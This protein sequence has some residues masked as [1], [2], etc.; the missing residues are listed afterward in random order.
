MSQW[1]PF[2]KFKFGEDGKNSWSLEHI[3][4]VNSKTK[5]TQEDWQKWLEYHI[6]QN[7]GVDAKN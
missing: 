4:A 3:N 1:F 5:G 2:D 7:D 6:K